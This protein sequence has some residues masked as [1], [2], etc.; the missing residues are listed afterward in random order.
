MSRIFVS[1]A[2]ADVELVDAFVDRLLRNGSNLIPDE[3][4]YTS[5]E[6]T[7]IRSGDDLIATVRREVGDATLVVALITPTYQTRPVCIAELGAAWS[8]AG[9]LIPLTVPGFT[10]ADLDG[11]LAGMTIRAMDDSAALDELHDR[12]KLASGKDVAVGD[13]GPPQ[14][15]V[16][17]RH[18]GTRRT[19]GDTAGC[20]TSRA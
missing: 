11:V 19:R 8:R 5:G 14:E 6:D 2:N 1:H 20:H 18:R 10:R 12:V 17:A 3:L 16:A 9:N 13:L 7:G 4:F 15:R